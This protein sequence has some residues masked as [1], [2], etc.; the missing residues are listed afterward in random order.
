M[1]AV[2]PRVNPKFIHPKRRR[3]CRRLSPAACVAPR[4]LLAPAQHRPRGRQPGNQPKGVNIY[5][6]IY[7]SIYVHTH[8]YTHTHTHT[9][10]HRVN[11][12]LTRYA[13]AEIYE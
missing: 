5:T 7:L 11:P 12:R 8:T 4:A 9:H 13:D 2:N 3:V 6:S 10:T 1:Q